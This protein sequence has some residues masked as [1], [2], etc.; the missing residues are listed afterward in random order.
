MSIA[1]L[2][3]NAGPDTRPNLARQLAA[4]AAEIVRVRTGAE[5]NSVNYLVRLDESPNPRLANV[6]A[7][8]VLN[9]YQMIEQ[10]FEQADIAVAVDGLLVENGENDFTLTIRHFERGNET[11]TS[12]DEYSLTP[13]T[14]LNSMKDVIVKLAASAGQKVDETKDEELFGTTNGLAFQKFL[15]GFDAP[16]YIDKTQG[17]VAEEFSPESACDVLIEAAELDKEWEAPY[18]ALLQL[19]RM[20]IQGQIGT[21][22]ITEKALNKAIELFPEDERAMVVL[23]ELYQAIGN[24][25]GATD[26]L[27]KAIKAN[28]KEPALLTR[29]GI[30]QASMNMPVNAERNFRAALAMEGEDKP[31]LDFLAQVLQQTGRMHEVP[32]LYQAQIDENAQNGGAYVKLAQ[33][34]A[35]DGQIDEALKVFEK[36]IET[37]TENLVIKRFYAPVLAQR[38]DFDRAMDFYEDCLDEAPADVQLNIEY[39]QTLM[40]AGRQFEVPKILREVLNLNPDQNTRANL[41]AWLLELEQPKRVESVGNAQK[42][43]EAEDFQGALRDLK[44]MKNWLADYWKMWALLAA[45]LNRTGEFEEAEETAKR[46]I[47]LFPGCEMAYA[48]L[49]TALGNQGKDEECYHAMRFGLTQCQ[50]SIPIGINLGLAARRLGQEDEANAIA[51]GIREALAGQQPEIEPILAEIEGKT[52]V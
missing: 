39:A 1:V 48:E 50:G 45:A 9:E 52:V 2:P 38:E 5:V 31:S 28:D 10:L 23:A 15:E 21:A 8:E 19:C 17:R 25:Q 11:P 44:P 47:D 24:F 42:K 43:L 29:L 51:A 27:E 12:V 41:L 40:A 26:V 46:L 14:I 22:E 3:F 6:N 33:A 20:C 34:L 35:G 49:A 7:A 32:A 4:Y 13:F 30:A 37:V 36:G 18:I 16:T